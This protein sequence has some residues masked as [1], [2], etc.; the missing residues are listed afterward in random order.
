MHTEKLQKQLEAEQESIKNELSELGIQNPQ[1][2]KDWIPTPGDPVDTESDPNDLGDRSEDWAERRGTLDVLETRF[3]NIK[4]ALQ[5]I[6][7]NTFGTCEICGNTIES[8]RLEANP[9]AR[10]CKTHITDEAKLTN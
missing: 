7:D 9:A 10:T 6:E 5:K 8:E 2:D 1:T 3:N 4:R